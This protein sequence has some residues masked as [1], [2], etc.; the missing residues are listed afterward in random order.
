ML[1]D[2]SDTHIYT[3]L[4]MARC[5]SWH[6]VQYGHTC[7]KMTHPD[8]N[9]TSTHGM[10]RIRVGLSAVTFSMLNLLYGRQKKEKSFTAAFSVA[11]K[12]RM[13]FFEFYSG[14]WVMA[15][16]FWVWQQGL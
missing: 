15:T 3:D 8:S 5:I 2:K 11:V 12:P 9:L 10:D 13:T 4:W 14:L 7:D 6:T 1:P 16:C